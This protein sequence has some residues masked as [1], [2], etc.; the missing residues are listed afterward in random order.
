MDTVN[1]NKCINFV[2]YLFNK[3][4]KG[5]NMLKHYIEFYYPDFSNYRISEQ[6]FKDENFEIPK[7]VF[8][9]RHFSRNEII[10]E[11]G[12]ILIGTKK[13]FSSFTYIG[14]TVYTQAEVSLIEPSLKLPIFVHESIKLIKTSTGDWRIFNDGDIILNQ[15]K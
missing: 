15:Q 4:L 8:A 10:A 12:E 7:D 5:R 11:D 3:Q 9:Y 6:E 1:Y 14:G 13:N 2:Y